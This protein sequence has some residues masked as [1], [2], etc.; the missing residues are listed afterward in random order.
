[1][2]EPTSALD[3]QHELRVLRVLRHLAQRDG[4]LVLV[5]LH[6]LNQALRH[7]DQALVVADGG[8]KAFGPVEQVI[9][10][11][12]L[13]T[14]YHVEAR[15]EACSKALPAVHVDGPAGHPAPP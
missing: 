3:L 2:D 13:R 11:E 8:M 9:T 12:L 7:A 10:A 14:V 15:V 1:M 6:D 5:A 4:L